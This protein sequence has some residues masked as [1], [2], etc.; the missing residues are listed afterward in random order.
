MAGLL[1]LSLVVTSQSNEVIYNA[2]VQNS[3]TD[4]KVLIDSMEQVRDKSDAS[5]LELINYQYGYIGWCMGIH[6]KAGAR[7]YMD[8][9]QKHLAILAQ[10]NFRW[11]DIYAYQSAFIGFEIGL[12]P[13]KAPFIGM[14]SI[15]YAEKAIAS[16]SNNYLG[17]VQLG[18]IE[19]YMPAIFGG[20]KDKAL[21]YYLKALKK[22]EESNLV[23]HNNWNYLNL[24]SIIIDAAI[25]TN[26]YAQAHDYCII[27][28]KIS[29]DFG[30]VKDELY[31]KTLKKLKN[32]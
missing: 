31:P 32:E 8:L 7:Y 5:R 27:A 10:Q 14:R 15:E 4:W 6:D 18:N 28:L 2:Y 25:Q 17:Y 11:S 13:L 20:S 30:W 16:D 22:M 24:L 23:L 12:S 9:A 26:N 3:M 29:P 1:F 19:F 21:V